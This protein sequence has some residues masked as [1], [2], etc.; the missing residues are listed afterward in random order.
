[1]TTIATLNN[2]IFNS[3]SIIEFKNIVKAITENDE[4]INYTPAFRVIANINN[5][6][7]MFV[8]ESLVKNSIV[9]V[10]DILVLNGN[11]IYES[12][13]NW[14]QTWREYS[15]KSALVWRESVC[16]FVKLKDTVLARDL[17]E[18]IKELSAVNCL[19]YDCSEMSESKVACILIEN[20][21]AIRDSLFINSMGRSE[22]QTIAVGNKVVI[23]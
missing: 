10:D 22:L 18:Y 19:I 5:S 20:E 16:N 21:E 9:T 12:Y 11:P 1:M 7:N 23:K 17:N 6:T 13:M 4:T 3:I 8:F 15:L 14:K 2:G